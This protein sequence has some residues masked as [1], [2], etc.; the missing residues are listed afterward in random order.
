MSLSFFVENEKSICWNRYAMK[1]MAAIWWMCWAR[2]HSLSYRN[3]NNGIKLGFHSIFNFKS[4]W[5]QSLSTSLFFHE[6]E[7]FHCC[8]RLFLNIS[9][10]LLEIH[11]FCLVEHNKCL[12]QFYFNSQ[13]RRH[14]H[15]IPLFYICIVRNSR[16]FHCRE[17]IVV[18]L[19]AH[20]FVIKIA[21]HFFFI[22]CKTFHLT[23]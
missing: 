4:K 6:S 11:F 15:K 3:K 1:M 9:F 12:T 21:K 8:V 18:S 5:R 10:S 14:S 2:S 20:D 19:M 17:T 13:F 7:T 23:F 16:T 22:V